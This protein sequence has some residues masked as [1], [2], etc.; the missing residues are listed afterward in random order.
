[1]GTLPSFALVVDKAMLLSI[2][3]FRTWLFQ[4]AASASAG[5]SATA[6]RCRPFARSNIAAM[7]ALSAVAGLAHAQAP[8]AGAWH[9]RES[10]FNWVRECINEGEGLFGASSSCGWSIPGAP[11]VTYQGSSSILLA[12]PMW[13][14]LG[15]EATATTRSNG[16]YGP[17]T[18]PTANGSVGDTWRVYGRS[19]PIRVTVTLRWELSQQWSGDGVFRN[20]VLTPALGG[21]FYHVINHGPVETVGNPSGFYSIATPDTRNLQFGDA[22]S[23]GCAVG[24]ETAQRRGS[25]YFTPTQWAS[26]TGSSQLQSNVAIA[27]I[28]VQWRNPGTNEWEVVPNYTI[29][30]ESGAAP[31][32]CDPSIVTQ[33]AALPT[34]RVGVVTCAATATSPP[35][36]GSLTYQWQATDPSA[37]GGWANLTEGVLIRAGAPTCATVSGSTSATLVVGLACTSG[38]DDVDGCAFRCVVTNACGSTASSSATL[39]I[40]APDDLT[41][42]GPGCDPDTNQ[43]GVVDQ[44]DIDYLI[45]VVA[46][47]P[48]PTGIDPDFTR[49]GNVDQ[50]DV[51]ALINVVA[52]GICP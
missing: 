15:V 40:L 27:D 4:F 48:N 49:D 21:N 6:G 16:Q 36:F 26:V 8:I 25:I 38:A 9:G 14:S 43:D 45:D 23:I 22:I 3:C 32:T 52:G 17:A 37:P 30:S 28:L 47:G 33:P 39:T 10:N 1:M 29:Q 31:T 13:I 34:C 20:V 41:C 44:G 19:G 24:F 7:L 42:V 2:T 18:G 46:G 11:G 5:A 12:R 50:S 35:G 51:D